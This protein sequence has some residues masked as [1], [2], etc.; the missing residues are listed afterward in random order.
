MKFMRKFS[1][2]IGNYNLRFSYI[3]NFESDLE[4]FGSKPVLANKH[5]VTSVHNQDFSHE[6]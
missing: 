1:Q 4:Q 5:S 2:N 6:Q 3:I